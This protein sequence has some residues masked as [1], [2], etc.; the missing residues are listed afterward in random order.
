MGWKEGFGRSWKV[1]GHWNN[2]KEILELF[3]WKEWLRNWIWN[4]LTG[5][6]VTAAGTLLYAAIYEKDAVAALI[7]ALAAGVLVALLVAIISIAYALIQ[8]GRSKGS[9][10]PDDT[11]G[12]AAAGSVA[13]LAQPE[14]IL[15]KGIK[16]RTANYLLHGTKRS[17]W[18]E[19]EN[20]GSAEFR[21][22]LV[23][24]T[25]IQTLKGKQLNTNHLPLQLRTQRQLIG[26]AEPFV[27]RVGETEYLPLCSK[28]DREPGP[29]QIAYAI[30]ASHYQQPD[31]DGEY[32]VTLGFYG[33]PA[34]TYATIQLSVDT[35]G[36]LQ[37]KIHDAS[38]RNAAEPSN[39]D[40]K[41]S[42]RR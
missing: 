6:V 11:V 25:K 2:F 18:I 28:V 16:E 22:C 10:Q 13:A 5:G 30:G 4:S 20:A 21:N 14:Q 24:V 17:F 15:L 42:V 27:L 9:K 7:A 19:V 39:N 32:L 34:P 37:A 1:W 23:K 41:N 12:P 35:L 33:S 29:I 40:T 38:Q 36:R 3:G 26:T 8:I 31:G